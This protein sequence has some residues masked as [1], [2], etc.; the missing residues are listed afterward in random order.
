MTNQDTKRIKKAKVKPKKKFKKTKIVLSILTVCLIGVVCY[1]IYFAIGIIKATD[2]FDA[3]RLL[4]NEATEIYDA[5]ENSMGLW[6][7]SDAGNRENIEYEQLPQVMIDAVVSA[8][9][10]RYF[11]HSGIDIPRIVKAAIGNV[12]HR[13]ITSGGSTITQQ[14]IKKSYW[15]YSEENINRWQRKIAEIYLATQ[16]DKELSKEQILVLYLNKISFGRGTQAIGIQAASKY[17]FN[18]D[19]SMLTLPEAALVAGTLN[20]PD[21]FDPYYHIEAA[22]N[23]RNVILDLMYRHGYITEQERDSAKSVKVENTL[24]KNT[25]SSSNYSN[26]ASYVDTVL[27]EFEDLKESG[28]FPELKGINPLETPIEIH[29]FM[30]PETQNYADQI[31]SGEAYYFS[32][33]NLEL[34]ASIQDTHTGAIVAVIGGR[35][36]T[37]ITTSQREAVNLPLINYALEK[38]QPGSSLKPIISYAAAFEYLDWST[39]Q[40]VSNE[41]YT[42]PEGHKINNW[43]KS[44]GGNMQLVD[45]L[46]LSYN[47]PA[48]HTYE[49][50]NDKIGYSGYTKYLE[51]FGFD[52]SDE[53]LNLTYSIGSWDHGISPIEGAGAYSVLS[54]GGQYIKPHTINYI[55]IKGTNTKVDVHDRITP[56]QA[57]DASSAFMITKVLQSFAKTNYYGTNISYNIAGKSGTSDWGTNGLSFETPIPEGV[58][59]DSWFQCYSEDYAVSVWAGYPGQL[60]QKY[61]YYMDSTQTWQITSSIAAMLLSKAH[62]GVTNHS[63]TQPSNVVQATMIKDYEPYTKPTS[64]MSSDKI[65]T[66][67]F[68]TSNQ[69][70]D[71]SESS[72]LNDLSSFTVSGEA[73]NLTA[74]FADYGQDNEST[75][76]IYGSVVYAIEVRDS[77]TNE[78]L[79]TQQS[80]SSSFKINYTPTKSVTVAGYYA[81]KDAL[82]L[83]SSEKTVSITVKNTTANYTINYYVDGSLLASETKSG[84]IGD[85]IEVNTLTH[86]PNDSYSVN[87]SPNNAKILEDG[88]AVVNV[89]YKKENSNQTS[90][91]QT[92]PSSNSSTNS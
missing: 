71:A 57:I 11:E 75:K 56:T 6:G 16:A 84:K 18:K 63:Y 10:S 61:G 4:S 87:I 31:A 81:R 54:N 52:L 12:V 62:N 2:S 28:D 35:A 74:T 65:V 73:D 82:S 86:L 42:T 70:K 36:Y 14:L 72:K 21:A 34:G 79:Y 91:A 45:A 33:D 64:D 39:G 48:I 23:R 9:D 25:S 80:D 90:P 17:Y 67:W 15:E 88:T 27:S 3:N 1:G 43:D 78:V 60:A 8:E 19:V 83:R 59:K 29:T 76:K 20:A 41:A 47:L 30:N 40:A 37:G 50:V 49:K 55:V 89:Y 46:K 22:T 26:Y 92:T 51:G 38:H 66:A 85:T 58:V 44:S 7:N 5:N 13:G 53:N 69:P 32:D 24:S 68:K 77:S